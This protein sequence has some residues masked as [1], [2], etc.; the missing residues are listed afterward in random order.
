MAN[1]INPSV[2][3][4]ATR[5]TTGETR[6]KPT[7]APEAKFSVPSDAAGGDTVDARPSLSFG[8]LAPLVK[9]DLN[10]DA[11][12]IT[13]QQVEKQLQGE[14]HPVVNNRPQVISNLYETLLKEQQG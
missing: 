13:A 8:S 10:S 1:P 4:P 3:A 11:A 7:Q 5:A 6:P 12:I 9:T 14:P 2:G